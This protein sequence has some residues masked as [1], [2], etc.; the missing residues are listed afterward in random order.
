[1]GKEKHISQSDIDAVWSRVWREQQKASRGAIFKHRL[2]VEGYPVIKKFVPKD[3]RF[4]LEVGGG[5]GRYGLSFA[6]DLPRSTVRIVDM[7]EESLDFISRLS[8]ELGLRNVQVGREDAFKLSFPDNSF[9]VVFSDAVIQH[10]PNPEN[11]LKE[12]TR[13]LKPN[14]PLIVSVVNARNP[15]T[16]YKA[17][18]KLWR[19]P[20]PYGYEKSFTKKELRELFAKSGLEVIAEDGFY[21]AYGIYRLKSVHPIFG[22]LGKICNRVVKMLDLFTKRFVSRSF[23]FEI[24]I[25]G[26]K[27]IPN[28]YD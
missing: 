10:F 21:T 1:M 4:I 7:V 14:S 8:Q 18:L 3:A 20:Y 26:K 11:A 17:W 9:D 5:S 15:H 27:V 24:V 22:L 28:I 13:V 23:G 6:Q 12:M 25:V 16:L 2:F 19:K